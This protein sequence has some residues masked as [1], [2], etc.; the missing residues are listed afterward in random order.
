MIEIRL[1]WDP[2]INPEREG[3]CAGPWLPLI[4][5][6]TEAL[7]GLVV[8]CTDGYG[9]GTHWI[10]WRSGGLTGRSARGARFY[11]IA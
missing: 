9:D 1:C 8:D 11:G 4:D 3:E 6:N 2:A 7:E 10:E 5:E